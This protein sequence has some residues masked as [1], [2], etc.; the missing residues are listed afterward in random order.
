[1]D[2]REALAAQVEFLPLGAA[3]VKSG[4]LKIIIS[5]PYWIYM[6]GQT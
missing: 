5:N 6:D 4:F 1:M 3:P 2:G